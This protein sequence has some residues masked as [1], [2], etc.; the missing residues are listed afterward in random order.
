MKFIFLEFKAYIIFLL[1]IIQ[2]N[3]F[4]IKEKDFSPNIAVI[5]FKIFYPPKVNEYPN[6]CRYYLENIHSTLPYLEMEIGEN[7]KNKKLTKNE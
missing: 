1:I 6:L 5:P 2:I 3:S 7:I 4:D